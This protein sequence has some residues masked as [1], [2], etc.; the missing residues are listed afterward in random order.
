MKKVKNITKVL[1]GQKE[2]AI[3]VTYNDGV[4]ET[5]NI[6][7]G[8]T[9]NDV[10]SENIRNG[11]INLKGYDTNKRILVE[12]TAG[13]NTEDSREV[14]KAAK[15]IRQAEEDARKSEERLNKQYSDIANFR[16]NM[17]GFNN[18]N[19]NPLNKVVSADVPRTQEEKQP[20]KT[21]YGLVVFGTAILTGVLLWGG[22]KLANKNCTSA[23]IFIVAPT[24][25]STMEPA[26]EEIKEVE[27]S[28]LS[29]KDVKKLATVACN[30]KYVAKCNYTQAD[31]ENVIC[32]V[33]GLEMINND[34]RV[35]DPYRVEQF[36]NDMTSEAIENFFETGKINPYNY[37]V[38]YQED[39]VEC[40]ALRN[41]EDGFAAVNNEED[42]KQYFAKCYRVAQALDV[43]G[44]NV[45]QDTNEQFEGP[46][47]YAVADRQMIYNMA[48]GKSLT[49]PA[50]YIWFD[51]GDDYKNVSYDTQELYQRTDDYTGVMEGLRL[52]FIENELSKCADEA[53]VLSK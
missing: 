8:M 49:I 33:N 9:A 16:V 50:G 19:N 25:I 31:L 40:R 29:E 42:A 6:L 22:H 51:L 4:V 34:C 52:D 28:K 12:Q 44:I 43:D 2:V 5:Y 7:N 37:S 48:I 21:R 36:F 30:S 11:N 17:N 24:S 1:E 32:L 46:F 39:S 20:K 14:V 23:D 26:T 41:V 35:N 18:E 38:L 10:L 45:L 27:N 47:Y 53:K 3:R 13:I 15:K